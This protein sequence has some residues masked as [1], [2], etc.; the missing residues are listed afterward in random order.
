MRKRIALAAGGLALVAAVAIPVGGA[1]GK[2]TSKCNRLDPAINTAEAIIGATNSGQA[3][4]A[5]I[6]LNS[7]KCP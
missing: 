3:T 7:A 5:G 1:F 4:N 6:Y 2:T